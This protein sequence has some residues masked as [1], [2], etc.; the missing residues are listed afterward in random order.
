MSLFWLEF[1]HNYEGGNPVFPAFAEETG[2]IGGLEKVRVWW[3]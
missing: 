1:C 2:C 3:D